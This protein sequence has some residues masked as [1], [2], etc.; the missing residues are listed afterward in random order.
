MGTTTTSGKSRLVK[1]RSRVRRKA[2]RVGRNI[3]LAFIFLVGVA[4]GLAQL[5]PV[6][7]TP[8][9]S[10][11]V[12]TICSLLSVGYAIY[13]GRRTYLPVEA[14]APCI[15][16]P[17]DHFALCCPCSE[18]VSRQANDLANRHY[19]GENIS[20]DHY[21]LWRNKNKSILVCLITSTQEVVGYFD[22]LPLTSTFMNNFLSGRMIEKEIRPSDILPR[23]HASRSRKLYLG[24]V[25]VRDPDMFIGRRHASILVWGLLK[26]IDTYYP[27]TVHRQ[28]YALA[29]TDEGERLLRRFGFCLKSSALERKDNHNLYMLDLSRETLDSVLHSLPDW[30]NI[31]RLSWAIDRKTRDNEYSTAGATRG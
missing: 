26:Y 13:Q 14:M 12:L 23:Q 15:T 7:I 4:S 11:S 25:A 6:S 20:F 28:L 8:V 24:G 18:S 21:E 10:I 5:L 3:A 29:A 17:D 2:I 1:S 16:G 19:A 27:P 31:C 30:S 9:R 22:V